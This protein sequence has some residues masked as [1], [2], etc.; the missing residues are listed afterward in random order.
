[1]GPLEQPRQIHTHVPTHRAIVF[2]SYGTPIFVEDV[3]RVTLRA[4][5]HED[6]LPPVGLFFSR[7]ELDDL[8]SVPKI[9]VSHIFPR[10]PC[11]HKDMWE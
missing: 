10:Q 9:L 8:V 11:E 5:Q 2:A 7:T 3:Q 6:Y 1:M 4:I